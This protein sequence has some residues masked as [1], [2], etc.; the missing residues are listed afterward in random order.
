VL[1]LVDVGL[2]VVVDPAP[3]ELELD[4]VE[5]LPVPP[6]EVSL[7]VVMVQAPVQMKSKAP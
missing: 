6:S 7:V 5:L 3:P 2:D 4:V 1:L